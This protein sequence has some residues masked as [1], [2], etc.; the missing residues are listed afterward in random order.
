MPEQ[1]GQTISLRDYV[2]SQFKA[3]NE[4]IN[5]ARANIEL[6]LSA[7][8]ELREQINRE[9]GQYLTR[10]RFDASHIA[11]ESRLAN[12]DKFAANIQGRIWAMGAVVVVIQI[13][14]Q[15]WRK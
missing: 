6:R 13:L 3:H 15:V 7:M 4:A 12:L 10:D 1:Q 11:I 8:N 9:R 5:L 14:L 2:D